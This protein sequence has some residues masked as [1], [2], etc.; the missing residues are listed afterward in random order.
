LDFGSVGN[1]LG[2]D[3][4]DSH[5]VEE[6]VTQDANVQT[7]RR[8]PLRRSRLAQWELR[9][10]DYRVFFDFEG[11]DTVKIVAVGNKDHNDL[12]IRGR[13]AEL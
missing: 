4:D 5:V 1:F 6:L 13:K 9:L 3:G 8:K 11:S 2:C 10:G 7:R 12:Y